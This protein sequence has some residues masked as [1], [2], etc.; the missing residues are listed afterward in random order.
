MGKFVNYRPVDF[1]YSHF[2]GDN[3]AAKISLSKY[4]QAQQEF[5]AYV[6][7]M[8]DITNYTI[9]RTHHNCSVEYKHFMKNR[10]NNINIIT[11]TQLK[12]TPR[13]TLSYLIQIHYT[14]KQR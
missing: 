12:F 7:I 2:F 8:T 4:C 9:S 3:F 6:L 10:L 1:N 11:Y 14:Y 5:E 13:I